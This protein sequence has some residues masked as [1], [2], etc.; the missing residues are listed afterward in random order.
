MIRPQGTKKVCAG[1]DEEKT[2]GIGGAFP[3][4][5]KLKSGVV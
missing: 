5:G 3:R 1:C 2:V 4:K